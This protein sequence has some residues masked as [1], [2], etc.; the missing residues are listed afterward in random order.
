MKRHDGMHPR[1]LLAGLC[2]LAVLAAARHAPAQVETRGAEVSNEL[3]SVN[4]A[5]HWENWSIPTH[6][7]DI[8]GDAVVPHYFRMRFN[9]LEDFRTYRRSIDELT[10]PV[11]DKFR[12]HGGVGAF[13]AVPNVQRT[14][15]LDANG[16]MKLRNDLNMEK[17]LDANFLKYP[18]N[19]AHLVIDGVLFVLEDT[20]MTAAKEGVLTLRNAR[21]GRT[22]RMDFQTKDKLPFPIYEYSVRQGVSRLGSGS[23]DQ[24]ALFDGDPGTYW[25]PDANDPL[26]KWW[27]EIDLGRTVLVDE[28]VLKFADAGNGDPFRQFKVL[29]EPGQQLILEEAGELEFAVV[30]GTDAPNEDQRTFSFGM[31]D[32]RDAAPGWDGRM[33]ETIRIVVFDT[34]GS[35]HTRLGSEAEWQ[36]LDPAD[37]GDIVHFVRDQGGFEEPVSR[38]EYDQLPGQRQG[39]RDFYRRERPRLSEVEVWGLGDNIGPGIKQGGGSFD[40]IGEGVS[41]PIDAFDGD[42]N[43]YFSQQLPTPTLAQRGLMVA[44]LG[45]TFWLDQLRISAVWIRS[46]TTVFDGYIHRGSDGTSDA[47]G[48]LKW[49]RLSS[50]EREK[51]QAPQYLQ[52]KDEYP[53]APRIR[54]LETRIVSERDAFRTSSEGAGIVEYQ[55][56]TRAYPAEVVLESDL[57]A[58][59]GTRNLGRIFWDADTPPGTGIEVRT[60]SGDLLGKVVRYFDDAGKEISLT[61]WKS[62]RR[63]PP[64]DTVFVPTSGW[65]PWSNVYQ[66]SGDRVT[67]PGLRKYLQAQVVLTTDEREAAARIRSLEIELVAPVGERIL[68]EVWPSE[69]P[70]PGVVDTF[71]VYIRPNFIED[72]APSRS[73]GF[74]E[75]LLE[76]GSG[77]IELL[78]LAVGADPASGTADQ[79]FRPV[80]G[81]FSDQEGAGLEVLRNGADSIWVRFP[82]LQTSRD[83]AEPVYH[84][85][86]SEGDEVPVDQNGVMLTAAAYGLL[87][88]EE[89]G[90]VQYFRLEADGGLAEVDHPDYAELDPSE[91]GP[92]RY[93]RVLQGDGSQFP[94]SA[95]G[96][97]LTSAG[98]SSLGRA[99]RGSVVAEGNLM[100]VTFAAPVYRNGTT[101]VLAARNSGGGADPEAPWQTIEAGDATPAFDGNTLSIG[102]PLGLA[103]LSEVEISPNPFTPNGDGINDA[104]RIGLSVFKITAGRELGVSI[105]SLDGRRVWEAKQVVSGGAHTIQWSGVDNAGKSVPPGMYICRIE[106][107]VDSKDRGEAAV[108]RLISVA[109]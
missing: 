64:P 57:F 6:A 45:A 63:P 24:G 58:L 37:R 72:P 93:F 77:G 16:E 109:Y 15:S 56:Y 9:V 104:A 7:V 22:S 52:I 84:R 18:G 101:L 83:D 49:T 75:I 13:T 98:Y 80:D 66:G 36:D 68:A 47:R 92:V 28:I 48:R 29:T 8:V 44:D 86:T 35:R 105:H 17:Y 108:A 60:R 55:L 50:A 46:Y 87:S 43:T 34:K 1:M 76:L 62:L 11:D 33:V 94:F 71:E 23:V 107:D 88:G 54:F 12:V 21:T 10:W 14:F 42:Y 69:V 20:T 73:L 99:E 91:Q 31:E 82:E 106:L 40:V 30:A 2:S 81:V 102:V 103:A 78:E 100:R 61:A 39:R 67:S 5:S 38:E 3:I 96:D 95:G 4:S 41:S 85:I 59:P 65:S 25:E 97:T 26:E 27:I 74:D 90:A 89:Q 70:D 32:T 51:N 79:T 53:E 19:E